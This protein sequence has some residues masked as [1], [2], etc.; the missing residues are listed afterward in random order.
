MERELEDAENAERKSGTLLEAVSHILEQ[1]DE[2]DASP[3]LLQETTNATSN[4]HSSHIKILKF[5]LPKLNGQY[6][7]WIPFYEQFMASVDSNPNIP[8]IQKF[9]YLKASLT[10][11]ALQLV[12]H[13]PLSNSNYPIALKSLLTAITILD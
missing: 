11:E 2:T 8:A 5:D 1:I 13:L 10:D 4:S 12:A 3:A 6:K 9:N 7:K